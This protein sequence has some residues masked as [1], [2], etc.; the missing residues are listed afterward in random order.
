LD[1]DPDNPSNN[2]Y[3]NEDFIVWMRTAAMPTFRKLYRKLISNGSNTFQNGLP[4]GN[5]ILSINYSNN[6]L[7]IFVFFERISFFSRLS[8]VK[9][10]RKKTIYN[11]Y[12]FLDGRKKFISWLGLYRR[13]DFL[14]NCIRGIFRAA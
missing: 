1:L 2:G 5:Y 6:F 14:Y 3:K 4:Q 9:F 12:N 8:S 10:Q 7:F 11:Q 13:W